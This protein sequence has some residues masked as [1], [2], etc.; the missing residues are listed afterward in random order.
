MI[1]LDTDVLIEIAEKKSKRGQNALQK[2]AQHGED[3]TICSITLHEMLFGQLKQ[4]NKRKKF[5]Q[6]DVLAFTKKDAKLA[7]EIEYNAAKK[8]KPI[9]RLDTMVAAIA[10][11]NNASLLTF[12][13]KHFKDILGLKLL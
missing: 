13:H 6:M 4:K 11:N 2:I 1:L 8:G 9:P 7:A 10:I 12:N 5:L 3:I